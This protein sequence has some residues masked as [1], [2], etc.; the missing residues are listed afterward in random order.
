MR[1]KGE[2]L[3]TQQT[4]KP[5]AQEPDATPPLLLHSAS[6]DIIII[7]TSVQVEIIRYN[8][9]IHL[10]WDKNFGNQ[11]L[12]QLLFQLGM[13][14]AFK[15]DTPIHNGGLIQWWHWSWRR[16]RPVKQ[17]PL[18]PSLA[19]Q[20]PFWNLTIWKTLKT[21]KSHTLMSYPGFSEN[22]RIS[23]FLHFSC[24]EDPGSAT[25][26]AASLLDSAEAGWSSVGWTRHWSQWNWWWWQFLVDLI[27]SPEQMPR[28][29]AGPIGWTALPF[30]KQTCFEIS[31]S[32]SHQTNS[33]HL[34]FHH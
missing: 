2:N 34:Q 3:Q 28:V 18:F 14:L 24:L 19:G 12:M 1:K 8:Y 4:P 29:G 9:I 6:V 32:Q 7:F 16:K 31:K 23:I 30:L 10:C 26:V 21:E 22:M 11:L 5:E 33:C 13:V 25:L 17:T 15:N 27:F 20:S